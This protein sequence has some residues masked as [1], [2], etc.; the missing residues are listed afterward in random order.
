MRG[1]SNAE[2]ISTKFEGSFEPLVPNNFA[3]GCTV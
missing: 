3:I 1:I 2:S